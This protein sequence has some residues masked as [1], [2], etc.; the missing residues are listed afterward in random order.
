[1]GG[2]SAW[3]KKKNFASYHRKQEQT[4]KKYKKQTRYVQDGRGGPKKMPKHKSGGITGR[5]AALRS[6]NTNQKSSNRHLRIN[7]KKGFAGGKAAKTPRG[8]K[9]GEWTGH[10]DSG[11]ETIKRPGGL[12]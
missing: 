3:V 5:K 7:S 8:G 2:V 9:W 1:L 11:N 4:K 6:S 10:K 12:R